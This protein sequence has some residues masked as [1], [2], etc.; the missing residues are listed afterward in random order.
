LRVLP[1]SVRPQ[2]GL[3]YLLARTADTI[4]DTDLVAV[5]RR[6]QA[7][8][9]L[10]ER[11]LGK[12]TT[13]LNLGEL[14][15]SQSSDAERQLLDNC[16]QSLAL[17]DSLS[18]ADRQLT[19]RVLDT[20]TSGQELDLRRFQGASASNV[21]ALETDA[22][23]D[24]Y[25]WRVAG[26]VGEFWTR[27]CRAHVYQKSSLD[28]TAMEVNGIRFGKGL[29]LVNILRDLPRDLRA[30]RCYLPRERLAT[31]GLRPG[32]L[33]DAT[34]EGRLRPIYNSYLDTAEGQLRAGWRYTTALPR[35]PMRLK[36]ACAWPLLIGFETLRLL[37][38]APILASAKPVKVSRSKVRSIMLRS[39]LL[40]P[41]GASWNR[42]APAHDQ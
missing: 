8:Q 6:L 25:T 19:V 10:R 1:A 37:R 4:A 13:P 34:V 36:L 3:A 24:D 26:C 39:V 5:E 35:K 42:L 31:A 12:T 38:S 40:F 2:I 9:A 18:A 33:L 15:G 20:V 14:A 16:E 23:T 41:L 17:L 7:L 11:I 29:Q 28:D 22:E 32:D 21:L 27:L 30:G